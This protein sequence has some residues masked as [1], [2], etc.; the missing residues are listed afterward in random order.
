MRWFRA[1]T[2]YPSYY[3]HLYFACF[4]LSLPTIGSCYEFLWSLLMGSLSIIIS[5]DQILTQHLDVRRHPSHL[6]E[7]ISYT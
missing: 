1:A 5:L 3:L 2:V 6:A 4:L 7:S